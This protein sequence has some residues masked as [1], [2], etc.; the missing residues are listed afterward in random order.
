MSKNVVDKIKS[1]FSQDIS[2]YTTSS[3][4][5]GHV[6]KKRDTSNILI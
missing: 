3:Y 2:Y 5:G 1:H 6:N 4:F